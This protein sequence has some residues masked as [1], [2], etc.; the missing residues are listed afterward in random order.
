MS[1]IL[2]HYTNEFRSG[3]D[4]S[5][6]DAE[7]VF[8]E[9]ISCTDEDALA[10]MLEAWARKGTTEDELFRFAAIMRS[11][12]KRLEH[13]IPSVTDIVGTGG[14][15]SKTINVSTAAAFVIAAAGV[16]VAKHGNRA[17]TSSSGSSDVLSLLGIDVDVEIDATGDDLE[18]HGLCFMFAPRFHSLSPVLAAAR[19]R[20]E[21][22]TV[23][24]NIGPL[25]NPASASHHV[26][27]VW[28]NTLV[29]KTAR[30]LTRLGSERSW[31]VFGTE[32]LDEISLTAPTNVAEIDEGT[33]RE[34]S[35]SAS[36]FGVGPIDGDLPLN[37]TARQSADVIRSVLA[38]E[39][40]GRDAE[41]LVLINAAAAIYVAGRAGSLTDAYKAAESA[42]RDGSAAEKL[43]QLSDLSI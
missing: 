13:Q 8:A 9:M 21:S 30:V 31:V 15:R 33:I 39:L 17:A 2:R 40:A 14:S 19:R 4:V 7:A 5:P 24:N 42:V 18:R 10:A 41:K 34:F 32:G 22:P 23:F 27:G 6:Y 43:R 20:V 1:E 26:I 38:N 28:D 37:C 3:R 29:R 11:R 12:M 25:C 36:D 16:P 35:V